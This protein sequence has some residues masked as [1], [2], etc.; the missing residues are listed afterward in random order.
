MVIYIYIYNIYIYIYVEINCNKNYNRFPHHKFLKFCAPSAW[1]KCL[2][3]HFT[4]SVGVR[5][6]GL[7]IDVIATLRAAIEDGG[8]SLLHKVVFYHINMVLYPILVGLKHTN[9]KHFLGGI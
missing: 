4:T 6:S 5:Q 3:D 8:F 1:H 2:A 9:L 7:W